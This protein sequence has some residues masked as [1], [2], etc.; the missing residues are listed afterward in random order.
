LTDFQLQQ[1]A[2]LPLL[3][4][5]YALTFGL[6][7]VKRKWAFQPEDGS[8]HKD[9]KTLFFSLFRLSSSLVSVTIAEIENE[10]IY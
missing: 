6:N 4:T 3:A 7:M 8:Q 1:R 5:T 2:L 10:L 9:V